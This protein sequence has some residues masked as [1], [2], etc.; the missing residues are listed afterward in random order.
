MGE[1]F[2]WAQ[3]THENLYK[4]QA[5]ASRERKGYVTTEIETGVMRHEAKNVSS[6]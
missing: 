4:N 1:L 6:F 2:G 5:G 3:F